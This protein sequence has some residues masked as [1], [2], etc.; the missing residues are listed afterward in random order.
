MKLRIQDMLLVSDLDGTIL[1]HNGIVSKENKEAICKF[2]KLGGTFTIA[3]GRSPIHAIEYVKE[4]SIKSFFIS[5]NGSGIYDMKTMNTIWAQSFDPEAGV[6]LREF[7]S[8]FPNVGV[9]FI[10]INQ[11]FHVYQEN[12]IIRRY[13]ETGLLKNVSSINGDILPANCCGGWL[14]VDQ[15][16]AHD[17]LH[18]FLNKQDDRIVIMPSGVENMDILP[19]GITKGA[20]LSRLAGL[21][22]KSLQ[23]TIAIGD[24]NNDIDMICKAGLGVAVGNALPEVKAAA[25]M[26]VASCEKNGLAELINHLILIADAE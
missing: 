19:G 11:H 12:A 25:Q 10:D 18:W 14:E 13:V 6:V 26:T 8:V 3:T 7:V 17:V 20:S 23:N 4:L 16:P 15:E 2:R 5:G 22:G 24:Y 1:P 9:L 21:Y